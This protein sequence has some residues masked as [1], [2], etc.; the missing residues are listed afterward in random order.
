MKY[1]SNVPNLYDFILCTEISV[2]IG[3][4]CN[5]SRRVYWMV[6][7]MTPWWILITTW[8]ISGMTG[9]TQRSTKPSSISA[10]APLNIRG[11]SLDT[12]KPTDTFGCNELPFWMWSQSSKM[13]VKALNTPVHC[14]KRCEMFQS[15]DNW[16]KSPFGF[17][18]RKRDL[19]SNCPFCFGWLNWGFR[20][21]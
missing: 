15:P 5:E 16:P 9:Q 19:K 11:H 7:P 3:Q 2:K 4:R 10:D 1:Y 14:A 17:F 18:S 21:F 12:W 20:Y 8:T 6:N 13:T